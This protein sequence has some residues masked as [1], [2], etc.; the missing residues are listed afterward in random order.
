RMPGEIGGAPPLG[1]SGGWGG[2]AGSN[3]SNGIGCGFPVAGTGGL[4]GLLPGGRS[5]G[6]SAVLGALGFGPNCAG[7]GCV[8][9]G[10]MPGEVGG[11]PPL[12]ESGGWGGGWRAGDPID[13]SLPIYAMSLRADTS[14][15][16]GLL[17]GGGSG[18]GSAQ[19]LGLSWGSGGGI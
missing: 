3:F 19:D 13:A 9:G 14:R 12:G 2:A 10:G 16:A 8:V 11:A 5:G 7:G 17:P 6:G 4:A 1:E 18:G 15:L